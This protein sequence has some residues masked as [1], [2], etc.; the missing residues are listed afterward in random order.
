MTPRE[1]QASGGA[2]L[3]PRPATGLP[4][5]GPAG[6][7][8][9]PVPAW[10]DLFR[11]LPAA[12][13][14][15]LLDLAARQGLLYARQLPP[16]DPSALAPRRQLLAQLLAGKADL[17]PLAPPPDEEAGGDFDA[18]QRD[19]VAR[20][21]ATPDVCLI[22]GL[23]GSGKSRVAAEIVCRAA[24]R[25]ERV[26]LL[27]PGAAAVDRVL[28]LVGHREA[29][30]PVRC[31]GKDERPE[32]LPDCARPL[33]FEER[34]RALRDGA[35]RA[36]RA[37]AEACRKRAE[38]LRAA[39]PLW[40]QIEK[41]SACQELL[42]AKL[43][44]LARRRERLA[45]DVRHA[46]SAAAG[47]APEPAGAGAFAGLA[48]A[49]RRDR[50]QEL[51][52]LGRQQAEVRARQEEVRSRRRQAEEEL[53][54]IRPMVEAREGWRLWRLA[55]WRSLG[56]GELRTRRDREQARLRELDEQAALLGGQAGRLDEDRARCEVSF[57]ARRNELVEAESA[58]RR[59]ELDR[60]ETELRLEADLILRQWVAARVGL[61]EA[62]PDAAPPAAPAPPADVAA[63]RAGWLDRLRD[64]EARGDF[65]HRWADCLD[66]AAPS[67]P[68]RLAGCAN[69]VAAT[70]A[71]LPADP[72]FG[73]HSG[74][75]FDLLVLEE[76]D[77]VTEPELL[78]AA[79]RAR[80]WALV[81]EPPH[82]GSS[83][84]DFRLADAVAGPGHRHHG[85]PGKS[86]IVNR[87]L[88]MS[89]PGVFQRLWQQLSASPSRPS[90]VWARAG[91]K[92]CCRL[93]PV[94]PEHASWV[95]VEPVA[96]RPDVEL[97]IL[98]VPGAEPVLAEI[99]FPP[100]TPIRQAKEY[101]FRELQEVTAHCRGDAATWQPSADR[102]RL[103]LG[104]AA[105]DWAACPGVVAVPL[106]DGVEEF[107]RPA[108][109]E[110]PFE[111]LGF[112]FDRT[113]GW[114]RERAEEWARRHLGLRDPGRTAFLGRPY[115]ARGE[116][117]GFVAGV[118]F[119]GNGA[120]GP[121]GAGAVEFVA[122][123]PAGEARRRARPGPEAASGR[124]RPPRGGA[125]FELDLAD[126][127]HAELLP[128][129]LHPELPPRGLVN[130]FEARAVVEALEALAADP[131]FRA[132]AAAWPE[133]PC[134]APAAATACRHSP[135]VAVTALY[136]AQVQL[137]RQ[138]VRQSRPLAGAG[139][140]RLAEGRYRL[141][142]GE[143][144]A[145]VWVDVPPAL[146]QR[147]CLAL[148]LSLTRSHTHRA[149]ALGDD[150]DWLPLALTRPSGRLVL[151][152]DPGTLRRRT[153]WAGPVD[154]LDEVHAARERELVARLLRLAGAPPEP[155]P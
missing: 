62:D 152:G 130:Y 155:R 125:G 106:D 12:Q 19:A 117:S 40:E 90:S 78:A 151:F 36:A 87:Q 103:Q 99:H 136:P 116:L 145:E 1:R 89:A 21:L 49:C 148:L 10:D 29:I 115:R 24:A 105:S 131:A 109:E 25:G 112:T 57:E 60:E 100:E 113:A 153:Q 54:A 38:R 55:F 133:R 111:T 11:G 66:D 26:L 37:E 154:H 47:G 142:T 122:V 8:D 3:A 79:R 67:L 53:N 101:V 108:G 92:L 68:A 74:A 97:R 77:R 42:G 28:E 129:G 61:A 81:G 16:A 128:A 39:G 75:A 50:E 20:A 110:A 46:W 84:P 143:G 144:A 72:H 33:T 147:E 140:A 64:E 41:H 138:L 137:I 22:Q 83:I 6:P 88:K 126:A 76:A 96:D 63:R 44:N 65:A 23:P 121:P 48:R 118:L 71:A 120:A 146:R 56:H 30:C 80:R 134:P 14:A 95:E 132:G 18:A 69:V 52:Q 51:E 32:A 150:P 85:P 34:A 82:F 86:K 59:Q 5:P 123:P 9:R 102:I 135:A 45:D 149:V 13:Q 31:L 98:A 114:D 15:E 17:A 91:G 94:A 70:T 139:L 4:R 107:V 119:P 27:A 43:V 93:R 2:A 35:G 141:G 7:G 127:A 58:R 73:D 104:A 124:G